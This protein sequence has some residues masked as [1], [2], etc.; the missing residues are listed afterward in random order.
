MNTDP[1]LPTMDELMTLAYLNSLPDETG[2]R[3]IDRALSSIEGDLQAWRQSLGTAASQA[4][5]AMSPE[6]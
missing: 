2:Q 4:K 1:D 5:K 6:Q 3:L